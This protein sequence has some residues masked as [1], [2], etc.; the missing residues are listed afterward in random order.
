MEDGRA[1]MKRICRTECQ[2]KRDGFADRERGS[3]ALEQTRLPTT[4]YEGLLNLETMKGNSA[5]SSYEAGNGTCATRKT[6]KLVIPG[7]LGGRP[8]KVLPQQ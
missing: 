7:A 2:R 8:R 4:L 3:V 6:R 1:K 5:Q